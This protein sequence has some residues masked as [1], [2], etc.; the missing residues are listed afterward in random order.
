MRI[1]TTTALL[2]AGLTLGSAAHAAEPQQ[3][4]VT[5]G[6]YAGVRVAIDPA[7]GKLRPLTAAE[8]AKLS[9]AMVGKNKALGAYQGQPRNSAEARLTKRVS[10]NGV[11]VRLPADQMS[12]LEATVAADGSIVMTEGGA[13]VNHAHAHPEA[14]K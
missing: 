9:A 13:P 8:N 14:T 12:Q 10:K 7:T 2:L 3:A 11:S 4:P 5:E 1:C 6:T